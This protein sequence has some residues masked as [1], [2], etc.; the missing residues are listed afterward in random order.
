VLVEEQTH[1]T[2]SEAV[3]RIGSRL[4]MPLSLL[5]PGLGLVPG[6][7]RDAVYDQ[8]SGGRCACA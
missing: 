7:L 6:P 8:V 3:L 2:K 5:V 1:Y 4:N